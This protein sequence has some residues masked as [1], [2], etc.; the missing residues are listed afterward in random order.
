MFIATTFTF[1]VDV[2]PLVA[3]IVIVALPVPTAVIL[4]LLSTVAT[5]LLSLENLILSEVSDGSTEYDSFILSPRF[6]VTSCCAITILVTG[7]GSTTLTKHLAFLL[8]PSVVVAVIYASPSAIP[9]IFPEL[10]T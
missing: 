10:F 2:T 9:Q 5:L 8:L 3:S 1:T 6:I 4:P 7:T